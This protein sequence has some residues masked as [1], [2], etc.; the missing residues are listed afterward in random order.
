MKAAG[1]PCGRVMV[2][3]QLSSQARVS[4]MKGGGLPVG[5]FWYLNNRAAKH[6]P[7]GRAWYLI[8]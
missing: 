2:P 5:A 8:N 3:E 7:A 6:K 4:R 1:Y